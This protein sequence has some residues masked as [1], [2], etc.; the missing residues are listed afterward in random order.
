MPHLGWIEAPRISL[1]QWEELTRFAAAVR[2]DG[3][4]RALVFGMVG[5]SLAPHVLAASVGATSLT[6]LDSTDPAA[7][8]ANE[9]AGIANTI[10]VN[11]SMPGIRIEV[12][13]V[14]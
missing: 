7:E 10:C 4:T 6:A 12:L 11:S 3:L 14:V 5:S 1:A 9:R 13:A 2:R 8:L